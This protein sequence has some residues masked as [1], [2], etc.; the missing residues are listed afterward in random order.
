MTASQVLRSGSVASS[1]SED[2]LDRLGDPAAL[3]VAWL[4]ECVD[5]VRDG[6]K[7]VIADASLAHIR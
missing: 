4:N 3:T 7:G 1:R 5:A 2:G 6:G